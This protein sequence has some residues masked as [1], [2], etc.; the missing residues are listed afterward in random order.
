MQSASA[1][2]ADG[3]VKAYCVGSGLHML[4]CR[5]TGA[6]PEETSGS[7]ATPQVVGLQDDQ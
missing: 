3:S 1:Q 4:H 2:D 5:S 7:H 6:R